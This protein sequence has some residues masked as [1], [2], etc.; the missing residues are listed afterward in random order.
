ML[1]SPASDADQEFDQESD[2][3]PAQLE[4]EEEEEWDGT[5]TPEEEAPLLLQVGSWA[6]EPSSLDP[7]PA[8]E[9]L[10]QQLP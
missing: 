10:E 2:L 4:M 6:D 1:S 5:P 9:P 7:Q 8:K 3:P